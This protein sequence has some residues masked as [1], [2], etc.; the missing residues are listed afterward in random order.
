VDDSDY[1]TSARP[2]TTVT[3]E[4]RGMLAQAQ[5]TSWQNMTGSPSAYSPSGRLGF[6]GSL[7]VGRQ[8]AGVCGRVLN[9][10][11]SLLWVPIIAGVA[12]ATAFAGYLALLG[13][14]DNLV[15]G[16]RYATAIRTFPLLALL[17]SIHVVGQ[18]VI[19]E[20]ASERLSGGYL[21]LAAAWTRAGLQLPRL[22]F[23]GVMYA[24]ERT[25]T[26]LLRSRQ[27][28][29]PGTL[30]A[31]VVDRAWDFAT[32][33]AIPV[34]LFEDLPAFKAVARS[35][36]LV[37]K[38]WGVQLT[39][40]AAIGVALFVYSLPFLAVGFLAVAVGWVIPGIAIMALTLLGQTVIGAAL[41]GVLSAALYRFATTGLVAPGFN[42][43]EMWAVFSRR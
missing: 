25:L 2:A 35:G 4:E 28:W 43:A 29:S 26:S 37:A 22:V 24:G 3:P 23:F 18:A 16:N 5:A 20:A 39:A 14:V 10:E 13:G 27:R 33:L 32:Y 12:S 17:I 34:I 31:D 7:R 1:F 36:R 41:T 11:R 19:I 8:L 6:F 38:R 40:N 9:S 15:T 30:A 21:S 42:E